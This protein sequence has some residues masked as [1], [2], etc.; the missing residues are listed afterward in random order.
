M[1]YS[2]AYS[3]QNRCVIGDPTI[4]FC[5]FSDKDN[6]RLSVLGIDIDVTF[7]VLSSIN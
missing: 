4:S 3:E 5:F 2:D 6:G 1:V 7:A